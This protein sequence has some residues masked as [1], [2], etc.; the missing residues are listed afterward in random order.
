MWNLVENKNWKLRLIFSQ[1]AALLRL[2]PNFVSYL[3]YLKHILNWANNCTWLYFC[4]INLFCDVRK[5]TSYFHVK[6][7]NK[8]RKETT[9]RKWIL[10]LCCFWQTLSLCR[11]LVSALPLESSHVYG[12]VSGC[13]G[14]IWI[15]SR[16]ILSFS[17]IEGAVEWTLQQRQGK[18]LSFHVATIVPPD[19]ICLF[20]LCASLIVLSPSPPQLLLQAFAEQCNESLLAEVKLSP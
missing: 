11:F 14:T 13:R 3:C 16:A 12:H 20:W 15:Y 2:S 1:L 18:S 7:L 10:C 4:C 5:S 9:K 6:V 19:A 17:C 8:T